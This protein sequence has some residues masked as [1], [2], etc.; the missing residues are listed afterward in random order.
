MVFLYEGTKYDSHQ[1]VIYV[2]KDKFENDQL[3]QIARP[4]E[5]VW[6][7]ADKYSSAHVYLRLPAQFTNQIPQIWL[8]E[9][10]QLTREGSREGSQH[11]NISIVW[12]GCENLKK[13]SG[14]DPGTVGFK[15]ESRVKRLQVR[16]RN[17]ALLERLV[18]TRTEMQVEE[19]VQWNRDQ[20]KLERDKREVAKV[21]KKDVAVDPYADAFAQPTNSTTNRSGRAVE[22]D[23]FGC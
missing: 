10:A 4:Q 20:S 16:G 23:F 9:C 15:S 7:H 8:D 14:M 3:L 18:K 11:P 12:T 6:F 13:T 5:D 22:E 21:V 2:G 17:D 19:F 1:P